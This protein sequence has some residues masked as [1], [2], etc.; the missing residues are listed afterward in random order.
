MKSLTAFVIV[1]VWALPAVGITIETVPVGNPGNAAYPHITSAHPNGVGAVSYAYRIGRTE[2]TNVQY[3]AFLNAVAASDTYGL[4][5]TKM[6]TSTLGGIVRG[7]ESGTYSYAVKAAALSGTYKYENKPVI[8]LSWADA[9]RFANWLNN[10]Q[11]VGSQDASTTEDGTYT[12]NG[13]VTKE[14]LATVSRNS[15]A[16]WC[17]P[18][19]NEWHKA[20][21]YDPGTSTYFRYP[22]RSNVEPNNNLPSSDTGNSANFSVAT[23]N[24]SYPHTDAGA[25]TLSGSPYGT[26]DQGGNV[27]EWNDTMYDSRRGLRG[28]PW[29][30]DAFDMYVSTFA[31]SDPSIDF[32][33]GFRV[34]SIPE[35]STL[36]LTITAFAN[37]LTGRRKSVPHNRV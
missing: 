23:H 24:T 35:P 16:V 11:P 37:L 7:G 30:F 1:F 26:F 32:E 17:L 4:Y 27:W 14:A 28:G 5:N 21:Y 22:T 25:Y 10:G 9:A 8:W 19:E 2:V 20:A 15:D 34:A 33:Y 36:L 12:L 6:A 29:S 18:S 31:F 3:T 13:A